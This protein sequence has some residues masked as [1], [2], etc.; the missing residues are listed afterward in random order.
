MPSFN[1]LLDA[2]YREIRSIYLKSIMKAEVPHWQQ[3]RGH[4]T[5]GPI[6]LRMVL[7]YLEGRKLTNKEYSEILRLTMDGNPKKEP[8]TLRQRMKTAIS[9]LGYRYDVIHGKRELSEAL[10]YGPVIVYCEME[11]EEGDPYKHYIVV[12]RKTNDYL[13]INDPYKDK[14]GRIRQE[15]FFGSL[16]KLHWGDKQWGISIFKGQ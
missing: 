3:R 4:Y 16:T 10:K 15:L 7:S 1:K 14:P 5:C 9:E 8:G 11:D 2:H 12:T 6:C 13:F